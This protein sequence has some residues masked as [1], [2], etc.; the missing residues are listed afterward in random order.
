LIINSRRASTI[1][2]SITVKLS[3]YVSGLNSIFGQ[4]CH[5]K[6]LGKKPRVEGPGYGKC[7]KYSKAPPHVSGTVFNWF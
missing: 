1:M 7:K 6:H 4:Q 3:E 2:C 5:F